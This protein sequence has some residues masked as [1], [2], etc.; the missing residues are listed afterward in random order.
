MT[1]K[2]NI[3]LLAF[4]PDKLRLISA[5]LSNFEPVNCGGTYYLHL[6]GGPLGFA[7]GQVVLYFQCRF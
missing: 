1:I 2:A 7:S 4:S 3:A 5:V 6:R